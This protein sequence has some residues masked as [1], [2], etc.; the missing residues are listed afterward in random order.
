MRLSSVSVRVEPG[1]R[2]QAHYTAPTVTWLSYGEAIRHTDL[3]HVWIGEA[4]LYGPPALV[5]ELLGLA[6]RAVYAAWGDRNPGGPA[7][8]AAAP[9]L[10]AETNE[11]E[12]G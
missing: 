2:V 9:A 12:A 6:L 8:E 5:V 3:V 11:E 1:D 10:P 4:T 7:G